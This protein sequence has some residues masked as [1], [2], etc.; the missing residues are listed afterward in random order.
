VTR[1]LLVVLL[2]LTACSA[3]KSPDADRANERALAAVEADLRTTQGVLEASAS[4]STSL[5]NYGAVQVSLV[6]ADGTPAAAQEALLD[7]AEALV[8]RSP[9]DPILRLGLL[10][11]EQSTPSTAPG[12]QRAYVG[13]DDVARL[14]ARL[15]P[16]PT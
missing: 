12:R 15:G 16:R 3:G 6:V 9:A 5:T 14:A 10:L 13:A 1:R 2:L 4:Y 7:T 11:T 8:W